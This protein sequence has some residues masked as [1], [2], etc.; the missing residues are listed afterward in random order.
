M[1]L[2]RLHGFTARNKEEV[3][4]LNAVDEVDEREIAAKVTNNERREV[5]AQIKRK[6]REYDFR[7]RVLTAYASTCAFCGVQLKL[8]EAAHIIP[9]ASDTS[10]DKTT[11]GIALCSLHHRAYDQNL[12]SFDENYRIEIS[13]ATI[14][15][16]HKLNLAGGLAGFQNAVKNAIILP[17]DKRDYPAGPYIL[18]SRKVRLWRS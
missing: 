15:E 11:N 4:I 7:H 9:V 5:I 8:V 16:L 17:A 3:R 14:S 12:V 18:E 6:Y 2:A 1:N 13:G 10:T